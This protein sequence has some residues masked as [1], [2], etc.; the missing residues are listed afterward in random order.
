MAWCGASP[1]SYLLL[2]ASRCSLCKESMPLGQ[3]ILKEPTRNE[4]VQEG[5]RS[6]EAPTHVLLAFRA[7]ISACFGQGKVILESLKSLESLLKEVGSE[8]WSRS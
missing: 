4:A 3:G 7:C 6:R 5:F 1:S 8:D 2:M